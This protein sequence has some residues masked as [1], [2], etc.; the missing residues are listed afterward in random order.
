MPSYFADFPRRIKNIQ[1][2]IW[3]IRNIALAQAR[4]FQI[5][6]EHVMQGWIAQTSHYSKPHREQIDCWH[7]SRRVIQAAR[8]TAEKL[9]QR[10]AATN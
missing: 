1:N 2:A 9:M 10:H 4:H 7:A 8:S 3:I 5:Q 6:N